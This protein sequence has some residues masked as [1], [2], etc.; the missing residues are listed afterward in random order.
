MGVLAGKT[1]F[2]AIAVFLGLALNGAAFA[3]SGD[4]QT[5]QAPSAAPLTD[6]TPGATE[7]AGRPAYL[8]LR[9][10]ED[11]S[12]LRGESERRDALDRIKYIP[13]GREGWYV[14]VGGEARLY[15]ENFRDEVWGGEPADNN[16]F[17]LQRLM[18]HAD[19]HF[20]ERV[21][22]FS[23]LK[24][25]A[26]EGRVGGPRP[27]DRD[28]LDAHQLFV[29]YNFSTEKNSSLTLRIGRQEMSFGSS[30]LIGFREGPNIRL[31]FDGV[32]LLSKYKQ[33]TL[34]GFAVKPVEVD[35]GF[36]DDGP[37]HGQTLWG[38]YAMRPLRMIAKD[39]KI[40]VYYFGLDKKQSRFN[41]G[42][43]REIRHTVGA[44]IWNPSPPLDYN[45]EFVYQFGSFGKG[46]IN[47]WTAASETGYTFE[48]TPLRPR[49][50]LKADV[51]S[52]DKDPNNPDLQTFNSLFPKGAYFGELSPI[53]PYNHT[54]LHPAINLKPHKQVELLTEWV[55][56][57]R[58]STRDGLYGVPGNLERTGNTSRERYVGQ[59]F[60]AGLHVDLDRHTTF[61]T[62]FARFW[63]G[64]FLRAAPPARDTTY[65]S[66]WLTY[67]F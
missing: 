53:G 1:G 56:Y 5:S 14:T 64:A 31:S 8:Q 24:S 61:D 3:Q 44:R 22:V 18:L 4:T 52:G 25:G 30:R 39:D 63:V 65:F 21:R 50:G 57:W 60:Y 43:A 54:D 49:L 38:V 32:R 13:L 34:D 23:Q 16:G 62:V 35:R 37:I 29:D 42:S 6:R 33:W 66:A 58:T 51:T 41:Q 12:F 67:K 47:A 26:I 9:Y 46:N 55:W 59:S 15:Y 20:G 10:N 36:F 2:G 7:S 17:W 40:D 19:W 48:H 27:P 28:D 11:W 45:Y